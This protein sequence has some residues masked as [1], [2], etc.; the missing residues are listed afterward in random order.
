MLFDEDW[1]F[2]QKDVPKAERVQYSD[3]EW[4]TLDLPHDWSVEGKFD[5]KNTTTDRCGYLPTGIAWYR[6]TID[7]S[8]DW[9]GKQVAIQFD[10]VFRNSTVWA[11]GKKLGHRPYG[12]IS[13]EYDISDIVNESD[14]ITFAV[15]VDNK[16]QHAARWYTGSGIYAH[17]WLNVREPIHIPTSGIWLRTQGSTVS[18]DTEVANKTAKAAKAVVKTTVLDADGKAVVLQ[19]SSV[20]LKG[21]ETSTAFQTLEMPNPNRW[22]PESPY[23]YTAVSEVLVDGKVSDRKEIRFGVR[24]IEWIPGKGMLL[25]GK[26]VKLRGVCQHQHGGAFG[27]AVPE[28]I[29]RY[30]VEQMKAMGCNSI[31]TAHNPHTP[32]FYAI[33]DELGIIVMDEF[34]DGWNQKARA[35]Y[36]AQAFDQW[37]KRDLTDWI[38]RDRNHPSIFLWS[39]GNETHGEESAK[40][41]LARCHEIDPTRPVTSGSS[42]EQLMDIY[43]M[44]GGSES[45]G[46]FE[47]SMPTDRVFIGTENTHTWQTRGYYRTHTWYRD[48]ITSQI[49]DIPNLTEKEIFTF[50]WTDNSKRANRKQFYKSSYDNAT[51]RSPARRMIA[52][53]RDI[54]NNAGMYRWTGHD[55]LGEAGLA[56]GAWPFKLFSGGTC[57]LA[58]FEKDLY[59]LYQSQ[60]TTE[61]MVHI[62]PHWTHPV[63]K[64]GTEI[65]VW[66]YSNC[67]EVELFL[68][69]KSLGKKTPGA[70]WQEMQCQWLVGWTPGTLVAIGYKDGNK[71]AEKTIRTADEP[72]KLQLSIDGEQLA[73]TGKDVVQ[74]RATFL[75]AEDEFYPYGENRVFFKVLG[76]GRIKALDNGKPNDVEPFYGTSDRTAFFGLVRAYI[77]SG[78]ED[79]DI[80]L[81]A[82]SILGDKKLVV[83]DTVHIDVQQIALRGSPQVGKNKIYYT[84]DQS[85]PTDQSMLYTGPFSVVP[86]TTVKALVTMNGKQALMMQERFAADVGLLWEGG[87]LDTD[88][89][90]DQAEAAEFSGPKKSTEG[91]NYNG[92]GYLDMGKQ[93]GAYVEW[94]QENDGAA[95]EVK[96][97]IRYSGSAPGRKPLKVRLNVNGD[98][99]EQV[100][101]LP[102]CVNW[103]K[104]WRTVTVPIALKRGANTIRLTTVNDQGLF[105][106]EIQINSGE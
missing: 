17:T 6:K 51:V 75:D 43:G 97:T 12:W 35:D 72:A 32:E 7:V 88:F 15:R 3:S 48:G 71:V 1:K 45:G 23:L 58:N 33:C 36:G 80:A 79:G 68:N 89:G 81:V 96:L 90:G 64:A 4:R 93:K 65:P 78:K 57:D 25:N 92:S 39:I 20:M 24:D 53:I 91:K 69:G 11:N 50:D 56:S 62:L 40:A 99:M 41:M 87:G 52:Q 60:W 94:Y 26:V 27:A 2:V 106:D 47:N 70:K 76:E 49:T 82:G 37:W 31:R 38:K 9:K 46:W 63:M 95:A 18:I 86:G 55:Y 10:G 13:F 22:S 28:K 84:I 30:R 66:V 59:Y 67:D 83:S 101:D 100:V 77:E 54:P 44:N 104:Q 73:E 19:E 5:R 29:I 34:V 85:V 42:E 21:G 14:S 61:P 103:G 16:Q 74:V 98:K 102:P 105:V 8:N